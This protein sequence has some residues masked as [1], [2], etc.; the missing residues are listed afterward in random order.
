[1]SAEFIHL[2]TRRGCVDAADVWLL[3]ESK[4]S[5]EVCVCV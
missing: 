3:V 1:M 4:L 5:T 2:Q